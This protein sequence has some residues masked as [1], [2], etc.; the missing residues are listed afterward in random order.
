MSLD[1]TVGGTNSNSYVTQA[2]ADSYFA[3]RLFSDAWDA[4][5]SGEQ[6][7]ALIMA[8]KR[9]D[10]ENFIGVRTSSTQALKWPRAYVPIPGENY[11]YGVRYFDSNTIPQQVKD[12]QC[13]YA[14]LMIASDVLAQDDLANFKSVRVGPISVDFN[15]PVNSGVLPDQVVRLLKGLRANSSGVSMVRS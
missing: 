13:E 14:L 1:A 15:Q 2:A 5:T 3:D 11:V 4:A 8:A 10:Q 12:A 7:S 9:I 6:D